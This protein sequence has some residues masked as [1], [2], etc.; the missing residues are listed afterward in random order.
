NG[1]RTFLRLRRAVQRVDNTSDGGVADAEQIAKHCRPQI[2]LDELLC[3]TRMIEFD[4]SQ[5]GGRGCR[6]LLGGHVG[7]AS[8]EQHGRK[9]AQG[10]GT[11]GCEKPELR[12]RFLLWLEREHRT[13]PPTPGPTRR[14]FAG[15]GPFLAPESRNYRKSEP[16]RMAAGFRTRGL[17]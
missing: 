4:A 2:K 10:A 11:A 5:L 13:Q 9:S 6:R 1:L 7:D 3:R 17:P 12:H 15:A 14:I 16:A 8:I